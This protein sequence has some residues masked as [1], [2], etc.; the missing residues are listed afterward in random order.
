MRANDQDVCVPVSVVV[1]A[2]ADSEALRVTLREVAR[3][4]R[5]AGGESCLIV[6]TARDAM[7]ATSRL[8]LGELVDR[9]LFEEQPGKSNALNAAVAQVRGD[10]VAFTDDDATPSPSWLQHLLAAFDVSDGA[11]TTPVVGVGGPVLPVFPREGT[12][13]WYRRF[14]GRLATCFLGPKHHLGNRAMDYALVPGPELGSVPLGANCAWLRS[15]LLQFP[16]RPELGPNRE[17]GMRGGEDTCLALEVMLAG[18]RVC[19]EPRARVYHPVDQARM[20][21][22]YAL[23]GHRINA[24]EYVRVMRILGLSLPTR[25]NIEETI[26]RA[27]LGALDRLFSSADRVLRRHMRS[28]YYKAL[29]VEAYNP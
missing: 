13:A 2:C 7:Q 5:A 10:I 17:T 25:A 29:L 18:G 12:P 3:Q 9:L 16:Y 28:E 20:T 22:D 24:I 26:E 14:L 23:M 1:T 21:V 15:S 27:R 4:A 11:D 19:Y 6:N 8:A